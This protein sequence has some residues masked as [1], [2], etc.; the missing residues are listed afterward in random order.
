MRDGLYRVLIQHLRCGG[1]DET[2]AADPAAFDAYFRGDRRTC[3]CGT[4]WF[5]VFQEFVKQL[6]E[7]W[8]LT[9]VLGGLHAIKDLDL[10]PGQS[11]EVSMNDM[12]IPAD[13]EVF[14]VNF[15]LTG[16]APTFRPSLVFGN[17]VH[18]D[19]FPRTLRVHAVPNPGVVG[20]LSATPSIRFVVPSPDG[21]PM[22]HLCA[23]GKHF[24]AGRYDSIVVPAHIAVE[25]ALTRALSA[26][27]ARFRVPKVVEKFFDRSRYEEK[28]K[29]ICSEAAK[30][31]KIPAL[32]RPIR[33]Q[34]D[35]LREYRNDIAHNGMPYRAERPSLT[36]DTAT[37]HLIAA[38]FGCQ[39]ARYLREASRLSQI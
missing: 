27:I 25:C 13:A 5:D 24:V 9:E 39:Y 34:L 12:G 2:F 15:M 33:K 29:K 20:H 31:L 3:S 22:Q 1:M 32:P 16:D 19:P 11:Q 7:R 35:L 23:A 38:L 21:T 18:L 28:L 36:K 4:D 17:D 14:D 30:D 8:T 26:W 10:A 6:P 37:T